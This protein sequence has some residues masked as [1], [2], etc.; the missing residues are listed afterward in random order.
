MKRI[1]MWM[2]V[3]L[4]WTA[5]LLGQQTGSSVYSLRQC[6]ETGL[7]NNL[8]VIRGQLQ[9]QSD[10]EWLT[11]AR[12]GMLPDLNASASQSFNQG[13]GIDPYTNAPVTQA[14]NS[15]SYGVSSNVVL[16]NGFSVQNNIQRSRL[17]LEAS[18][19]EYQQAKDN[20]SINIILAYLQLLSSAEQL[21]QAKSQLTVTQEQVK[22]LEVLS[23]EGAIRPADLS[24][25]RGQLAGDQLSIINAQNAL[26]LARGSLCRWMNI[27]YDGQLTVEKIDLASAAEAAAEDPA[28]VYDT[29]LKG[30]ALIKATDL[31]A[32][33]AARALK[34]ARGQLLPTLS[35]GAGLSTSYS[36]VAYQSRFLNA[37]YLP[38]SDSALVNNVRYPVYK[39]QNNFSTPTKIPYGDQLN[40]NLYTSFG[41][42]LSIPLFNSGSQRN[43]VRQAGISLRLAEQTA[44][45]TRIQLSQDVHA[46]YN[47]MTAASGRFKVLQDQQEAY[48]ESFRSAGVLFQQGV[49]NSYEY[50]IAKNNLDRSQ[51]NLI[52]AKYDF[53]LRSKILD[54][55]QGRPL[56]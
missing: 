28:S 10:K 24:D 42:S 43:R 47:N 33:T 45:T 51:I 20:L 50:L 1:V 27:P 34:V 40:N 16:F 41:F 30:L 38:S 26:A 12:L 5:E 39:V 23:K 44:R 46:A 56:W 49:T 37:S 52:I 17:A 54:Y 3:V 14:F 15:S 8:D 11:Q 53:V 48:R 35:F 25:L 21:E 22:R 19:M 6:I 32:Q 55:F 31:R 18:R 13:R 2:V 36:S 29:A 7:A 4:S 9:T